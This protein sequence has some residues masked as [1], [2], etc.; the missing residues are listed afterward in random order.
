MLDVMVK[1][2][3]RSACHFLNACGIGRLRV[4]TLGVY[5]YVFVADDGNVFTPSM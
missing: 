2:G 3:G 5:F 1:E 4:P